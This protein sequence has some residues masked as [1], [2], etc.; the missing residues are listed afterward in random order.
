MVPQLG[1]R[2]LL[3]SAGMACIAGVSGCTA[4]GG[5]SESTTP[6]LV[7]LTALN[8]DDEPHKVHVRIEREGETV[9]RESK[10]VEADGPNGSGAAV[11]TGYPTRSGP[12]VLSAWRDDRQERQADTLDFAEFDSECLGVV[13]QLGQSGTDTDDPRLAIFHT[14]NC[15]G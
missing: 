9:Y 8:Q 13:A 11:F 2:S 4:F 1:R 14:T 10:R 3:Q 12:Y 6:Q 5:E 15:A 7:E